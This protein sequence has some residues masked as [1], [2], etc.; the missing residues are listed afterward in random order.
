MVKTI[1]ILGGGTSGLVSALILKS[2]FEGMDIE[3]VRSNDIGIIGVGEGSTEHWT[4][5][6]KITGINVN[7]LLRETDG[8]FKSGIKFINWNGDNHYYFH[9]IH[10]SFSHEGPTG[11]PFVYAKMIADGYDPYSIVPKNI[12]E[13]CHAEPLDTTVNQFHFNT[14]KL[15][16][17][18]QKKCIEKNIRI[19]DAIIKDVM[20]DE[21]GYV[22]SL[23]SDNN[24]EFKSD[25]YIDCSGFRRVIGSKPGVKWIDCSKYLPMN[26]AIAFPTERLEDIP[27]HTL[28]TAMSSGWM[29]RIPTQG[30]FGNG[31]VYSDAFLSEDQAIAEAQSCFNHSIEIA[32]KV[33][34]VAGYVDK[35][36]VKNCVCLGLS[37]SF[38]E[39]LE[40]SS[41]GTSIQQAISLAANLIFWTKGEEQTAKQY[42][43]DFDNVAKNIIDFV[44]L[45]YFTRREDSEFWRSCKDLIPTDFNQETLEVFKQTLPNHL[46][47]SKPFLMFR[48]Q[49]WLMVMHGLGMLDPL[50]VKQIT[51]SQNADV[52]FASN[53][54][55]ETFKKLY[56]EQVFYSH[57][58]SLSM[59]MSRNS[60]TVLKV[61]E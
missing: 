11:Y 15:N 10:S 36:W 8:T 49:N 52:Q 16:E 43:V 21:L 61:N 56:S 6:L 37:G 42:N 54:A 34:F 9:S 33:K 51:D 26:S 41:I 50:K 13:S 39:P 28:S 46:F 2:R 40:A 22:S 60:Y 58:E 29:W 48:D 12:H 18:L 44:Q 55:I 45:H 14:F 19:T 27:S 35:F 25:F 47:F 7:E 17:F 30:R 20:L 32:K 24:Q 57:R 23:V 38:V 5:F 1:T 3:V 53:D 31:Y 4:G 59:L